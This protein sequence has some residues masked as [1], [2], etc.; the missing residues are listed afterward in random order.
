M[1][2][3]Q[4]IFL[5]DPFSY[6]RIYS[7]NTFNKFLKAVEILV[8]TKNHV[9]V[10]LYFKNGEKVN[11]IITDDMFKEIVELYSEKFNHNKPLS[12]LLENLA[13]ERKARED[14]QTEFKM[15][16]H[17]KSL[18]KLISRLTKEKFVPEYFKDG[19][20]MISK[21]HSHGEFF[22]APK[23]KEIWSSPKRFDSSIIKRMGHLYTLG[24][25][26]LRNSFDVALEVLLNEYI[27]KTVLEKDV[28]YSSFFEHDFYCIKFEELESYCKLFSHNCIK[29]LENE[30]VY[31]FN[32]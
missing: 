9:E 26:Y 6:L 31:Q 5:Q 32:C 21:F 25:Y 11:L 27:N 1:I 28:N 17:P 19:Y 23:T 3:Y 20:E 22:Y 15:L 24:D 13:A 30:H 4:D 14:A 7:V 16:A 8:L 12:E 2:N 10:D 18:I 29:E